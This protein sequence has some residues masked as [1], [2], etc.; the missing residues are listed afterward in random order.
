[1]QCMSGKIEF[2]PLE[3]QN[4]WWTSNLSAVCARFSMRTASAPPCS[5]LT[6]V[7]TAYMVYLFIAAHVHE[8]VTD[9]TN[10]GNI[11]FTCKKHGHTTSWSGRPC[12]QRTAGR[13]E[14]GRKRLPTFRSAQ[15][16]NVLLALQV[17]VSNCFEHLFA[18]TNRAIPFQTGERTKTAVDLQLSSG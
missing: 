9:T 6:S 4:P 18:S 17:T 2:K 16:P 13:R 14:A 11:I 3:G 12:A 8:F 10:T 7:P 15:E 1:M 5:M